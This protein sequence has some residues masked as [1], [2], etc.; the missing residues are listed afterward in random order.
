MKWFIN[1]AILYTNQKS[2][3]KKSKTKKQIE[4]YES[5]LKSINS[6][7]TNFSSSKSKV[8][9]KSSLPK[10]NIPEERNPNNFPSAKSKY[11]NT[12]KKEIPIYTGTKMKGIGTLHKSNAVPIFNDQDAIDQANMR[13]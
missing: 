4:Q 11:F 8:V 9:L 12:F 5:W 1:M 10:L 2:K 6:I 3:K 13:R 7:K